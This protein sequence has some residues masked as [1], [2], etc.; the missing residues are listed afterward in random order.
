MFC[1]VCHFLASKSWPVNKIEKGEPVTFWIAECSGCGARFDHRC[2]G[3]DI[4]RDED[5]QIKVNDEFYVSEF[6][7]E[8]FERELAIRRGM[9]ASM[10]RFDHSDSTYVEIGVGVG[11]LPRAAAL[12]FKN[13]YGLDLEV[14]TAKSAGPIPHNV[15]FMIHGDFLAHTKEEISVLCAWH[16]VEHLP[17]PIGILGPLLRRV[18]QR[19]LFIGQVPQYR[20]EYVFPAH[21]VFHNERSL[22]TLLAPLGFSPLY[23][24]RDEANLFLSFCFRRS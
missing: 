17:D 9:I 23:L 21:Y 3:V 1:P 6:S 20:E 15:E 14:E 2:A 19:G 7:A 16:V 11:L 13:V 10:T 8:D 22:I 5:E 12:V 4:K 18:E 24:E